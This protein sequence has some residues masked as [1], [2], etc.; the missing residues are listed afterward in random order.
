ML[1]QPDEE[2][3]QNGIKKL[4][5]IERKDSCNKNRACLAKNNAF[6]RFKRNTMERNA[7]I[8]GSHVEYRQK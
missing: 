4:S 3:T 2:P 8:I 6:Q 1:V 5:A 7:N